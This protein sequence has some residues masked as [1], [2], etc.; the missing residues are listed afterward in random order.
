MINFL[1]SCVCPLNPGSL[2]RAR[3]TVDKM[4]SV[5]FFPENPLGN[6]AAGGSRKQEYKAREEVRKKEDKEIEE[7]WKIV[8]T[9]TPERTMTRQQHEACGRLYNVSPADTI[10]PLQ[11]IVEAERRVEM[12]RIMSLKIRS[13]VRKTLLLE[14]L[15]LDKMRLYLLQTNGNSTFYDNRLHVAEGGSTWKFVDVTRQ[16]SCCGQMLV[17]NEVNN[18]LLSCGKCKTTHYCNRACQKRDWKHGHKS[19]CRPEEGNKGIEIVLHMCVRVLSYMRLTEMVEKGVMAEGPE[20]F[21][22][23]SPH[24]CV[25][26]H[27]LRVSAIFFHL[28]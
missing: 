16:C 8:N 25:H 27:L 1:Y 7:A 18:K 11:E 6:G 24:A 22:F 21:E 19:V 20:T 28:A 13:V 3:K 26:L 2:Y 23:I 9:I 10:T 5:L 12:L 17:M 4:E 14:T 15:F